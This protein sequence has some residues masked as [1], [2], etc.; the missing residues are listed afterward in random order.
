M[1]DFFLFLGFRNRRR[2]LGEDGEAENKSNSVG[3]K[4]IYDDRV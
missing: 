3:L 2:D 1:V 4:Y